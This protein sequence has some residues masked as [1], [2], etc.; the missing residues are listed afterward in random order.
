MY[1]VLFNQVDVFTSE[2]PR[3]DGCRD[4]V[5]EGVRLELRTGDEAS[6]GKVGASSS[7]TLLGR[8]QLVAGCYR[9]FATS[10]EASLANF[11]IVGSSFIVLR[12]WSDFLNM[13]ENFNESS[14]GRMRR[15]GR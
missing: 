15:G 10:E 3:S 4:Q 8:S 11:L 1:H 6:P 2:D 9:E 12:R 5:D 7:G 13:C 14:H